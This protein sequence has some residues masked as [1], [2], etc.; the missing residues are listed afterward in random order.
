MRHIVCVCASIGSLVWL[1]GTTAA[2]SQVGSTILLPE[3]QEIALALGAAPEDLRTQATVYVF[4]A[5]GYSQVRTGT[6]GFTCIVNRDGN[7]KGDHDL[8]PTCWDAEGSRTILPV[9][10]RVG[11]LIA[12]DSGAEQIEHEVDAG[13]REGRFSSPGKSGIA[14]MLEGDLGF[15]EKSQTITKALFPPHYMIYAPGVSN[16]DIGVDPRKAQERHAPWVYAG[17]SGGTRIAY[18]MVM[19]AKEGGVAAH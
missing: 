18:L 12:K 9:M 14:Y 4:T 16:A 19:A 3:D 10:L 11:E 15:D 5:T 1:T 8:K 17:Y 7:Q 2:S 13:F 6:N